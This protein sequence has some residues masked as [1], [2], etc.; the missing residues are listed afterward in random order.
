MV[1]G[2]QYVAMSGYG[3]LIAYSLGE[4][5]QAVTAAGSG[6]QPASSKPDERTDLPTAPGKDVTARVCTSCHGAEI[7]SSLRLSQTAW[8]DAIKRMTVRGMALTADEYRTVLDYLST[9]LGPKP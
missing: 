4:E 9:H 2:K 8:D 6:S 3:T 7:W 5:G 1:G